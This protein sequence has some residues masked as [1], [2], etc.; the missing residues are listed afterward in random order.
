ML[1]LH[2]S[3]LFERYGDVYAALRDCEQALKY[4][5]N[6]SKAAYRQARCLFE[7]EWL[8]EAEACLKCFM[9]RFPDECNTKLVKSLER[10][11]KAALYSQTE[12][13]YV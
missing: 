3:Y 11:I 6:N 1:S 4:D 13:K 2:I 8:P 5:S 7:L 12:G 10:D 9:A